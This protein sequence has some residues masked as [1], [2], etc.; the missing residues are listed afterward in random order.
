[1]ENREKVINVINNIKNNIKNEKNEKYLNMLKSDLRKVKKT[2]VNQDDFY[3][4][5]VEEDSIIK[6]VG[7]STILWNN[8]SYEELVQYFKILKKYLVL[9]D[10]SLDVNNIKI[11]LFLEESDII[12][13]SNFSKIKEVLKD[14]KLLKKVRKEDRDTIDFL[15]IRGYSDFID[16][17]IESSKEV[18]IYE[19]IDEAI[20]DNIEEFQNKSLFSNR[21]QMARELLLFRNYYEY[22]GKIYHYND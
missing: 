20:D 4:I 19:N 3:Y 17:A 12:G 22:N 5:I 18:S 21:E 16:E 7:E 1:M 15:L 10:I 9:K 13:V 11:K 2:F 8:S 6:N 14:I